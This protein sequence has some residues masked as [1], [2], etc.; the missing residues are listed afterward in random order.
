[1]SREH[2][3]VPDYALQ[4]EYQLLA[5]GRLLCLLCAR[6]VRTKGKP[7]HEKGISHRSAVEE[8]GRKAS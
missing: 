4:P 3:R 7:M 6:V 1:M 5:P 8:M 2:Y